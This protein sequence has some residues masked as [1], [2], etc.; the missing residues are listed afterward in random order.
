MADVPF[1]SYHLIMFIA[2][3]PSNVERHEISHLSVHC[4]SCQRTDILNVRQVYSAVHQLWQTHSIWVCPMLTS[5]FL[6]MSHLPAS[7]IQHLKSHFILVEFCQPYDPPQQL[8]RGL[9]DAKYDYSFPCCYSNEADF[10]PTLTS[11]LLLETNHK[12]K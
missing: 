11:I 10:S 2:L 9:C 3:S 5:S 12:R 4:C 8:V 1:E 6:H 7:H